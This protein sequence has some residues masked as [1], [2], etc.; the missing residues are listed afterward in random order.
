MTTTDTASAGS[1][2][3][4]QA[5]RQYIMGIQSAHALEEQATQL[6]SRQIERIESYPEV[7]GLVRQHLAETEVQVQRLDGI[8]EELGTSPSTIKDI[9][10]QITGNMAV[11]GHTLMSDEIMKDYFADV[12]FEAFEQATYRS[13]IAMAQV[14]G[15]QHHVP[16]YQTTL[17]EE[18]KTFSTLLGM[19][20][21]LTVR[22]MRLS[23][24]AGRRGAEPSHARAGPGRA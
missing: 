23:A 15:F 12:A 19:A 9:A 17:H 16:I 18:E 6:L 10:T 14:S 2:S 13:L 4:D 24:E 11:L 20:D 7:A 21:R 8:I 1:M 22:F 5:R 3:S